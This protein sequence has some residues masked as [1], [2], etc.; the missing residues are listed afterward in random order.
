M[1]VQP[2]SQIAS[3]V[4]V[5]GRLFQRVELRGGLRCVL[6]GHRYRRRL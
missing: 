4:W 1:K 6:D 3:Q 2:G 5:V